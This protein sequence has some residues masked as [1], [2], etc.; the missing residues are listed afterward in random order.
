VLSE[1]EKRDIDSL[2]DALD[3]ERVFVALTAQHDTF[4]V[5][6]CLD[7]GYAEHE[8]A[9]ALADHKGRVRRLHAA[10]SRELKTSS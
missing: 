6:L 7:H 4:R 10:I 3:P 5:A 1:Q 2:L 8:Q 9:Y